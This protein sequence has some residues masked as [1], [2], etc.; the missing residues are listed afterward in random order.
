MDE[1]SLSV[2]IHQYLVNHRC[3]G[4]WPTVA[5]YKENSI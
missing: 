1:P 4:T 2:N 3:I 5:M